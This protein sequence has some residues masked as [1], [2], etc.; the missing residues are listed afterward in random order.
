[1]TKY[2]NL[3]I[4][5]TSH[6]S[7]QSVNQVK[8]SIT[9]LTPNIIALELDKERFLA[10]ISA[11]QG[12][13]GISFKNFK[14]LGFKSFL[15][16]LIGAYIEKKLSKSTGILPGTE[17]ITAIKLAKDKKIKIA[18]IDQPIHI[19]LKRLTSQI[20]RKEKLNLIKELLFTPFSKNKIKFDLNKVPSQKL[21][22][23]MIEGTKTKYPTIHRVLV[24]ERNRYMAKGLYKLMNS[25][26]TSKI[27]AIVGAGHEKEIVGELKSI[28]K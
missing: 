11:K 18:L 21:I 14:K 4:L 23:K 1:M 28:K 25:N 22:K 8:S 17:M 19:T 13:R 3:T 20:T 6:I 27:L 2:K 24:E 12:K 26:L 9:T 16:N 15:L 5:G 10:L 7:K